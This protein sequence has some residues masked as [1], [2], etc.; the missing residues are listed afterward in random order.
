MSRKITV[1]AALALALLLVA[2]SIPL[3]M[4][5]AL[6]EQNKLIPNLPELIRKFNALDEIQK[7]VNDK[8]YRTA[9]Q[10]AV[11]AAMVRGYIE[12]LGDPESRYLSAEEYQ[13]FNRRMAGQA[14]ELGIVLKYSPELAGLVID[15]VKAGSTAAVSGLQPG[16]HIVKAEKGGKELSIQ[17]EVEPGKAPQA[18]EV[19]YEETA[20]TAE[21][22]S[23]SITITYERGGERRPPVNVMLGNAVKSIAERMIETDDGLSVGYIR[24]FHFFRNTAG[25][26]EA[27]VKDLYNKGA[28]SYI[29][30]VRGCAEGNLEYVCEAIDL[31]AYVDGGTGTLATLRYKDGTMVPKPSSAGNNMM[32]Y[33]TGGYVVVLMNRLTAG[34]A[35]LFAYDLRAF[36]RDKVFLVGEPTR[37]ISTVQEPFQ[38]ASVGGAALLTV[39]TVTPYGGDAAWNE[40]GV[41]PNEATPEETASGIVYRISGA[42]QQLGGAL[43]LLAGRGS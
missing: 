11:N 10:D 15:Q 1:G 19:F 31:F 6:R 34:V 12:G 33:A 26:I 2:A 21:A 9:A 40:N 25:Q 41:Q 13:S 4:M 43:A 5:F 32:A 8:F 37:G 17:A 23:I 16:D 24:V 36:N 20:V 28:V 42:E 39:G 30:D 22:A 14:P 3:T 29:L 38:L 7:S 27:A 35:E 18:I